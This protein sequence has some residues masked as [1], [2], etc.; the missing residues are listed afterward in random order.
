MAQHHHHS[1]RDPE[2]ID[3]PLDAANQS[4]ADA[5]RASFSVLKFIMVVLVA[6]F[7]LSGVQF[8]DDREEAVVLRFGEFVDRDR[9]RTRSRPPGMSIAFPYPV[10][11]TL[12]VPVRQDNVVIVDDHFVALKEREKGRP[13]SELARPTLDPLRDGALMTADNGLVHVKWQLTYRIEDLVHFVKTVGD[14]GTADVVALLEAVL[15]NAAIHVAAEYTAEEITRYKSTELASRVRARVNQ[16]LQELGT[17]ITVVALDIPRSS[18]PIP[19]L[20]A[21]AAVS[22]AENQKQ[23]RIREAEQERDAILNGCAGEAY[24][25]I[26]AALDDWQEAETAGD[27]A[28]AAEHLARLDQLVEF[29]A[30]G[31]AGREV[32]KAKSYYT[33]AVQGMQADEE[34]Y[35]SVMKEYLR[36]PEL[37]FAR[38]WVQTKRKIFDYEEVVKR[39]VPPGEKEIRIII[40]PDPKQRMIDEM[41]RIERREKGTRRK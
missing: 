30:G 28:A 34:E 32:S 4:L 17:G 16:R 18:V 13:L 7:L 9:D 19:T 10:D 36:A 3:A 35:N 5:L 37:L 33:E 39:Y 1:H 12:R 20:R 38:L 21:F 40:G 14:G 23:K 24:P 25:R 31:D 22:S 2:V 41:R 6:L 8:I 27:H 29:E 11:E 26:L 15:D